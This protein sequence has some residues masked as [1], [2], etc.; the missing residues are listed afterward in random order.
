[1]AKIIIG[2]VGEAGSGKG[3][4]AKY[5]H[6]KHGAVTFTFSDILHDLLKRLYVT[7]VRDNLIK[8]SLAV[9]QTFGQDVLSRAMDLQ[10][11]EHPSNLVLVDGIRRIDDVTH[12]KMQPGFHLVEIVATP[13]TRFARLKKRGQRPEETSMTWEDFIETSKKETEVSIAP[14]AAQ[15]ERTLDNNGDLDS[16]AAQIEKMLADYNL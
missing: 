8:I 1:M 6:E 7:P 12:L 14:I 16:L 5:L 15:A 10:V 11:A 9:R 4:V 13:E 3:T 2:L